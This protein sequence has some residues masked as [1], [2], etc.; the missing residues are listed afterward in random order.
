MEEK[1]YIRRFSLRIRDDVE[2]QAI[3]EIREHLYGI[4]GQFYLFVLGRQGSQVVV[5][6]MMIKI[7]ETTQLKI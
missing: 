7:S 6:P 3:Q 1:S 2:L 5:V 4:W